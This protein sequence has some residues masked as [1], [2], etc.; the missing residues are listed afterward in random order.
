MA[1]K[2]IVIDNYSNGK[3]YEYLINKLPW[4]LRHYLYLLI[5]QFMPIIIYE[6]N[7]IKLKNCVFYLDNQSSLRKYSKL[8]EITRLVIK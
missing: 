8:L 4:E 7:L 1:F 2:E 5:S 6:M 3:V